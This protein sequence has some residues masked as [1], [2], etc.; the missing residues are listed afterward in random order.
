MEYV[1]TAVERTYGEMIRNNCLRRVG[2]YWDEGTDHDRYTPRNSDFNYG[3][4][5]SK[6]DNGNTVVAGYRH[7]MY[8]DDG[9]WMGLSYWRVS[10]EREDL[11]LYSFCS[12]IDPITL[13]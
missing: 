2:R 6:H 1:P 5:S 9:D 12:A 4:T 8:W 3:Q 7:A 13:S 10:Q 11:S